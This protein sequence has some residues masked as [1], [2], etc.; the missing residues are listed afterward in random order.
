MPVTRFTITTLDTLGGPTGSAYSLNNKGEVT[1]TADLVG[2]KVHHAYLW[3][4]KGITNLGALSGSYTDANAIN[5]LGEVVG[6]AEIKE[7]GDGTAHF[8]ES[9]ADACHA[10]L[11]DHGVM[12]DLGTLGGVSSQALGINHLGQVVGNSETTSYGAQSPF[13]WQKGK[14]KALGGAINSYSTVGASAINNK[15]E[16]VGIM[17][18]LDG[19][20]HYAFVWYNNKMT[21]LGV[22]DGT[23][24][25]AYTINDKGQVA[26]AT[27]MTDNITSHA[28]VW[29]AGVMHYLP[30][31]KGDTSTFPNFINDA[32]VVVGSSLQGTTSSRAVL[33]R[34][35]R[36]VDLNKVIPSGTGWHLDYAAGINEQGQIV[37]GGTFHGKQRGFLLTPVVG[38]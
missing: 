14:M 24:S 32:G 9:T 26:G 29:K 20:S 38:Q 33:W 28:F 36:V 12:R 30:A 23:A 27:V 10:F 4:A 18:T 6:T 19:T 5:N 3:S 37:G 21:D 35:G 25:D 31:V 17:A 1:G 7:S 15:G 13:I 2:G 11:W 22:G 16:I 8:C 34:S